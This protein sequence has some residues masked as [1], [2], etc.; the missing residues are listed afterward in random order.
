MLLLLLLLLVVVVGVEAGLDAA[1]AG[2]HMVVRLLATRWY[3]DSW[4]NPDWP[5]EGKLVLWRS[6]AAGTAAHAYDVRHCSTYT[7]TPSSCS[8]TVNGDTWRFVEPQFPYDILPRHQ[9]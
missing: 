6:K 5:P 2:S 9:A 8:V 3:M 4:M 1:A 7:C